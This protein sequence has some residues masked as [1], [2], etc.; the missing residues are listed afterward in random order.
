M[1]LLRSPAAI[2]RQVMRLRRQGRSVAFVPTMGALHEGHCS[3]IRRARA[4]CGCVVVSIFVNPLQF[5]PREDLARY[6]RPLAQ[7]L[8]ACRR[9]GVAAVFLPSAASL[10]PG[11]F[12]TRVSVEGISD[13]LCG[14]SRPGHF[15]GV[16]TVVAKLLNIVQPTAAYF[17]QKDFQQTVVIRR[18]CADLNVAVRIRVCATVREPDGL[19][20]SSRNRYLSPAE[21]SEAVLLFRALRQAAALARS[22]VRA[23]AALMRSMRACLAHSRVRIDYLA[24]VDPR[25]LMPLRRIEKTA[26]IAA[27]VWLGKTRLIDNILIG[28]RG[29]V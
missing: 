10:Y 13:V 28:G 22:G 25:T 16:A 17:G 3:L 7:D 6:P 9:E 27:A 2:R 26:L 24:V 19:A 21:R 23:P 14:R 29:R 15:S 20:M 4:E 1:K 12:C 5:G 18:M 11:G 8:A